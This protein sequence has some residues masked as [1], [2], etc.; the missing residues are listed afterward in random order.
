[1]FIGWMDCT[2]PSLWTCLYTLKVTCSHFCLR[3]KISKDLRKIQDKRGGVNLSFSFKLWHIYEEKHIWV[4]SSRVKCELYPCQIN[5]IFGLSVCFSV[6]W[7]IQVW[8]YKKYFLYLSLINAQS[9]NTQLHMTKPRCCD[10]QWHNT[11]WENKLMQ[12]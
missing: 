10:V 3:W 6:A 9:S 4:L 1:M 11:H 7:M 2:R 12:R 8:R 5:Q